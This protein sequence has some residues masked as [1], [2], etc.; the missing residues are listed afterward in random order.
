MTG[1]NTFARVMGGPLNGFSPDPAPL[2]WLC[3]SSDATLSNPPRWMTTLEAER[4]ARLSGASGRDFAATRWLIRRA[5]AS[6]SGQDAARCRPADGRPDTSAQPPGW[7]LSLSHSGDMAGCAVSRNAA[8]GLDIE[9]LTRRPQ[10]QKVVSRWFAPEEQDWLLARDS[11]EAFLQVW[12]LKEAWLKATGRG[13]A[14]NLRTLRV[15]ADLALTGDRPEEPW[16]AALG[17][18]GHCLV[19]VVYQSTRR[20]EGCLIPGPVNLADPGAPTSEVQP[21]NWLF[22]RRI[23]SI[24][25][26]A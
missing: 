22:H 2:V 12:T 20:P 8:I 26:S 14:N 7:R 4:F 18:A 15:G 21:V 6:V 5:L 9:P 11:S 16:R 3:P 24:S 17:Q 19:A 25:R 13:I 23:H 1:S 10:W